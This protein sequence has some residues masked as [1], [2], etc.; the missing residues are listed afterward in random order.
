MDIHVSSYESIVNPRHLTE[1]V[2]HHFNVSNLSIKDTYIY[3]VEV[4]DVKL[5]KSTWTIPWS[6]SAIH[7]HLT[8]LLQTPYYEIKAKIKSSFCILESGKVVEKTSTYN[9]GKIPAMIGTSD[10]LYDIDDGIKGYFIINGIET[11]LIHLENTTYNTVKI[12]KHNS[13]VNAKWKNVFRSSMSKYAWIVLLSSSDKPIPITELLKL[14][15]VDNAQD[16]I[17]FHDLSYQAQKLWHTYTS[18][19]YEEEHDE[20]IMPPKKS[21]DTSNIEITWLANVIRRMLKVAAGDE[22]PD[23]IDD[24]IN[25]RIETSGAQVGICINSSFTQM[26]KTMK[27]CLLN[28]QIQKR[29]ARDAH[30]TPRLNLPITAQTLSK[31]LES[32]VRTGCF[33]NKKGLAQILP[34]LNRV[35]T[36]SYL[37]KVIN[38]SAFSSGGS[39]V[40]TPRMLS[41]R[42]YGRFCPYDTP[43]SQDKFGLFKSLV[44]GVV[45]TQ[46]TRFDHM[47]IDDGIYN[48]YVNGEYQGK[49]NDV[50]ESTGHVS[51]TTD[52]NDNNIS[53]WCDAGRVLRKLS[54][55]KWMD[56]LEEQHAWDKGIDTDLLYH[57]DV[58]GHCIRG[59]PYWTSNQAPRNVFHAAMA[60]QAI[61]MQSMIKTPD[62]R[63][64]YYQPPLLKGDASNIN[65]MPSGTNVILA[66]MMMGNNQEDALIFNKRSVENGLFNSIMSKDHHVEGLTTLNVGDKL[67]KGQRLDTT[68]IARDAHVS[69]VTTFNISEVD[70]D[71]ISKI[72][73]ES[74]FNPVVGDKFASRHG[75]KGTV[76][77]FEAYEDMPFTKSGIVPDIIM[78]PHSF[79]T[80]MTVGH[81]KEME[82]SSSIFKDAVEET[83]FDGIKGTEYKVKIAI[84]PIYYL[85]LHHLADLK[86]YVCDQ[87]RTDPIK[88][89]AVK[90][91]SSK[92]GMRIGEMERTCI[93]SAGAMDV[94]KDRF[95]YDNIPVYVNDEGLV[96]DQPSK[97]VHMPGA[98]LRATQELACL[99]IQCKFKTP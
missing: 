96:D 41:P 24:I 87:V 5:Q 13:V 33:D 80:R 30:I 36:N 71:A 93:L 68:K 3:N 49:C 40:Y 27:D 16:L 58:V 39:R 56:P 94:Y 38:V 92:G 62:H 55:G 1:L 48:L 15:E 64:I 22:K 54:N 67:K 72:T 97:I 74:V 91:A 46:E 6:A 11:V 90:G 84:A 60:K 65:D 23:N 34:R 77:R 53:V 14:K 50:P 89:Q 95:A 42:E 29:N 86:L 82:E 79:P 59:A 47:C 20:E 57:G 44:P 78:N 9:L 35:A 98:M 73:L 75:Q 83:M 10:F 37:S 28:T 21:I 51:V 69:Q 52:G 32:L 8:T 76:S 88:L 43:D 99:N 63:L 61:G 85:R 12:T 25:R 45:I 66:I 31:N 17:R 2:K 18:I 19:C 7:K 26:A 70:T 4:L 81:L